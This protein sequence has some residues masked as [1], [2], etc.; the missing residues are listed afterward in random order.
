MKLYDDATFSSGNPVTA[1]DVYD[2]W[3]R[4]VENTTSNSNTLDFIDWDNWEF[5]N[6][7]EFVISYLDAF[8]PALNYM[9]MCCFS[10]ID[11]KAMADATSEDFWSAPVGSGPYTVVENVSGSYSSYVRQ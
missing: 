7:K 2:S 4:N 5:I 8:G 11:T 6:D 9:T 1:Q 10:V 3:Y